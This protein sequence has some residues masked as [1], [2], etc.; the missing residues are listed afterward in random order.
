MDGEI[1]SECT[2]IW[3]VKFYVWNV[4]SF[5]WRFLHYRI[6]GAI[7]AEVVIGE[8]ERANPVVIGSCD[9]RSCKCAFVASLHTCT[10]DIMSDSTTVATVDHSSDALRRRRERER[11]RRASDHTPTA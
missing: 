8:R 6:G 11:E 10:C 5:Q 9:R 2:L 3:M 4:C 1:L 7:V